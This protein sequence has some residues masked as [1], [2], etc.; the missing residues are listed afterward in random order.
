MARPA[1]SSRSSALRQPCA[2]DCSYCRARSAHWP[3]LSR[4]CS[5]A[6]ATRDQ[7]RAISFGPILARLRAS[8]PGRS[9]STSLGSPAFVTRGSNGAGERRSSIARKGNAMPTRRDLLRSA[10]LV[11]AAALPLSLATIDAALAQTV[12][13]LKLFVPAAPGGGWDQTARTIEQVLRATGAVKGVQITNVGGAGGA[14]GLPQFLNQWKGQG[15]AL[16]VAGMVMVGA[17]KADP[18]KVPVAG[19]SAGGSDHILLGMIAKALGVVPTKVSYVAFAG[20]GPATAALLGNQVAAGISGYGEFAEQ[21]KAGKLRVIAISADKRQEDIAAPTLKEEGIDVELFNWRGVF[22]PPGVSDAQRKAMIAL[23]EKM[24]ATPQWAQACKT[25]EW[26]QITLLGDDYKA[27][28]DVETARI[29]G[30][31]K[32]LG[33]A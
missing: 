30:I 13:L 18:A 23:M 31:L 27:F 6:S 25:R 5:R 12:D 29:E 21:V 1:W 4:R 3:M 9:G 16:M 8:S 10:A 2:G 19:G 24:T 17:L 28:L 15:N 7:S 33:L 11:P 32:E 20:G 22:A 26:T 14:V